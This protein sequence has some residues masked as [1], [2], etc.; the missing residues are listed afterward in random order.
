MNNDPQLYTLE[1]ANALLPTVIPKLEQLRDDYLRLTEL[2]NE[3]AVEVSTLEARGMVMVAHRSEIAINDAALRMKTA[4]GELFTLGIE[5]K[6]LE[7]GLIDFPAE[8]DGRIVYLCWKLGEGPIAF[9]HELDA[10][11]AGRRPI[12]GE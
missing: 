8:R 11:F 9:W 4:L 2:K 6:N 5:V 12:D 1:S 3:I 10:G 7:W